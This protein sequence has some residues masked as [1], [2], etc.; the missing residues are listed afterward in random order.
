MLVSVLAATVGSG[1]HGD[2][3]MTEAIPSQC[4]TRVNNDFFG[5]SD[6]SY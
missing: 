4:F 3:R 1:T 5:L 6:V 2:I